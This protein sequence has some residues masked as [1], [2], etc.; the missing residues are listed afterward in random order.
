MSSSHVQT[1]QSNVCVV[2]D[3]WTSLDLHLNVIDQKQNRVLSESESE[4]K[5]QLAQT[6]CF[7]MKF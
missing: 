5:I 3:T 4:L 1:I 7:L 2:L 6:V